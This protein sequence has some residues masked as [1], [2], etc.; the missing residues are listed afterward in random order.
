[1]KVSKTIYLVDN[2]ASER[3][4]LSVFLESCGYSVRSFPSAESFLAETEYLAVGVMLL[5]QHLPGMSGLDLQA[6][7]SRRGIKLPII[8]ITGHGDMQMSVK[9]IKAGAINFLEKPFNT[10]DLLKSIGE[11]FSL[12]NGN[13]LYRHTAAEVTRRVAILTKR[14]REIMQHIVAGITNKD[15]AELLGLSVRTI[16]VHRKK[17][18]NK[19]GAKSI[20][21]LVWKYSMYQGAAPSPNAKLTKQ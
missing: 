8:F 9:A 7:L 13:K 11:A 10:E 6:E 15:M 18:M 21:D 12:A 14:E 17:V 2:D 20:P 3:H 16:E 1:M 5:D 4:T 19:M